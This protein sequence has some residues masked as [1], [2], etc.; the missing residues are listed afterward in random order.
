V[1]QRFC[2]R[3]GTSL[4]RPKQTAAFEERRVVTVLFADLVG[5][6]SRAE[7]LDPEDVRAI[8][9]PYYT[10]LRSE[11]EAFGG[12][13][14]KFIG[15][16][17]MA[18]FGAPVAHGD[19]PERAVR[20]ALAIRDAMVEMNEADPELDLQ[21]RIGVNTG[22]AIVT[23]VPGAVSS[24]GMVAGDVVNTGARLQSAAPVNGIL[25]GDETY[26]ATHATLRYEETGPIAAK[27][28][29]APVRAWLAL[30]ASS[31]PGER[32]RPVAPLVGRD[33]ELAALRNVWER[34]VNERRPHLVTLF[35]APG[36]GK[37]RLADEF[38]SV[39]GPDVA[40]IFKGRSL[41][42]GAGM[43]YDAF[44]Q[45]VKQ[46]A[47]IF[48]TDTATV[49]LERLH[50]AVAKLVEDEEAADTAAHLAL[51][52][53][54]HEEEVADRRMLFF[55]ARRLVEELAR[56]HPLVLVFEDIHWAE[57]G[58]L[59]LLEHLASLLR[60]VPVLLL[61]LSRPDLLEARPGW[62]G[63]LPSYTALAL[64]PL[65]EEAARD[66]ALRLLPESSAG[67]VD[68]LA[69]TSD[70]NPLFI[71]ELAASLA[72]NATS[73]EGELPTS[74]RSIVSARLDALPRAE[75][76]LLLDAS[77]IGKVFWVG[78]LQHISANGD[79]VHDVLDALEHRDFLR[80]EPVS[81]IEGD[82]QY[83][84]KH[85]LIREIAYATLPRAR[86]RERHAAVA[87]FLEGIVGDRIAEWA[88][89]LAIHWLNA[90]DP[91]RAVDYFLLAAEQ[92][93][94]GWAK[95]EAVEFYRRALE[96]IP[97]DDAERR[98]SVMVKLAIADQAVYHLADAERL[99][100][101]QQPQ[102]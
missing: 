79:S 48:D 25:V 70:G 5:F 63:G 64:E 2:G 87:S 24:E 59:D 98:R 22:E 77:P 91:G 69:V 53:G 49:A 8:L 27:G 9:S 85:V 39:L 37:S 20:A 102:A 50:A 10:R 96:L 13:V 7:S 46:F 80:R 16:A 18:V 21:L 38:G 88:P 42:Y 97:E 89:V 66:L 43:G 35:G 73:V 32:A 78:A 23:F 76:S 83:S 4:A 61:T 36:I 15:D 31:P 65:S 94:R 62:A 52:L 68:R 29:Q 44:A 11:L 19:D 51:L 1:G 82:I 55:S 30:G 54:L 100:R 17:V 99:L 95:E 101:R 12:A 33:P 92:A 84:F 41:P 67:D 6:T 75:R 60:D 14:E 90:G 71:E 45:H 56:E 28:K 47:G 72:E 93:G 34:V 74:V 26:R 57:S 86:R 81:R 3:C 58:L 40:R